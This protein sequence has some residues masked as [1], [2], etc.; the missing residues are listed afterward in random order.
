MKSE[1]TCVSRWIS[2]ATRVLSARS[3][4][5]KMVLIA[6]RQLSHEHSNK[7]EQECLDDI[8]RVKGSADAP[9][10]KD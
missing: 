4:C 5:S 2:Y 6:M 7:S 10:K 3:I 8:K 9:V 1:T